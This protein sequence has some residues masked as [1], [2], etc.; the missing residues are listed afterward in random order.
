MHNCIHILCQPTLCCHAGMPATMH[1]GRITSGQGPVPGIWSSDDFAPASFARD[2][3]PHMRIQTTA[4]AHKG[5]AD[6]DTAAHTAHHRRQSL[7]HSASESQPLWSQTV[8]SAQ[9]HMLGGSIF[10]QHRS[11]TDFPMHPTPNASS[12]IGT[13]HSMLVI[14]GVKSVGTC[15]FLKIYVFTVVCNHHP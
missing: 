3:P 13:L 12:L 4:F 1:L 5:R 6:T 9:P 2:P 7:N 8:S 11:L 10:P 14:I 15:T